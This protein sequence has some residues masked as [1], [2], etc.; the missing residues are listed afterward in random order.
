MFL[1]LCE[2]LFLMRSLGPRDSEFFELMFCQIVL[3]LVD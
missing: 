3:A 1:P 2:F